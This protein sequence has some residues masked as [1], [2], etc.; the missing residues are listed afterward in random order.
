MKILTKT[1]SILIIASLISCTSNA[2]RFSAIST[3]NVRGLEHN[4]KSREDVTQGKGE[5]CENRIYLTRVAL[6]VLLIFP[7]FMRSFDIAWGQEDRKL[8]EATSQAI[9][10]GK[11]KGVFEGD[12][13]VNAEV[14]EKYIL[15]PL[16]YGRFC[17][18]V[19]GDVVSSTTRTTG[20]LEKKETFERESSYREPSRKE[21]SKRESSKKESIEEQE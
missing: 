6:G 11:N 3:H 7:W 17:T 18:L 14:K 19:E 10:D 16:F 8:E 20:F 4:S 21:S 9:K 12:V 15:V 1:A 2:G 13:L 5:S